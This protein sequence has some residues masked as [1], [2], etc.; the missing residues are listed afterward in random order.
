MKKQSIYTVLLIMSILYVPLVSGESKDYVEFP[1]SNVWFEENQIIF[2]ELNLTVSLESVNW[3][4]NIT[5]TE[6]T[7]QAY[8]SGSTSHTTTKIN[9]SA[10]VHCGES[11][12][13]TFIDRT[14]N[15]RAYKN[16][17]FPHQFENN[18]KE[19]TFSFNGNKSLS[20]PWSKSLWTGTLTRVWVIFYSEPF[21]PAEP[22]PD[23]YEPEKKESEILYFDIE[24][25]P[26]K[27]TDENIDPNADFD[28]SLDDPA[29]IIGGAVIGVIS[30]IVT[31][32]YKKES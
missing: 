24:P 4:K 21:T 14:V 29:V 22:L 31:Y 28:I 27:E 19:T 30:L 20:D 16:F 1:E 10:S 7:F 11:Y 9:I 8:F 13:N 32:I 15:I 17:T 6:I 5:Y 26:G 25:D 18:T 23:P 3:S 12:E 2:N